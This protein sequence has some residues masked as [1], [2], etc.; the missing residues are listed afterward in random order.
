MHSLIH[1]WTEAWE[2][3]KVLAWKP[4]EVAP[5]QMNLENLQNLGNLQRTEEALRNRHLTGNAIQYRVILITDQM[6]RKTEKIS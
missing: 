2:L 3:G 1:S 5:W 4:I 6:N